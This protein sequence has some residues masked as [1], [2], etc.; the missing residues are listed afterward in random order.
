MKR[1]RIPVAWGLDLAKCELLKLYLADQ[2]F[3]EEFSRLRQKHVAVLSYILTA[4]FG[5]ESNSMPTFDDLD[6]KLIEVLQEDGP[7]TLGWWRLI[8]KIHELERVTVDNDFEENLLSHFQLDTVE[9]LTELIRDLRSLADQFGFDYPWAVPRLLTVAIIDSGIDKNPSDRTSL[10]EK[11][12]ANIAELVY[13]RVAKSLPWQPLQITIPAAFFFMFSESEILS[14][15]RGL[16]KRYKSELAKY[17]ISFDTLDELPKHIRWLFA[18][19]RHRL[20]PKKISASECAEYKPTN[21]TH[22]Q[23]EIRKWDK[24]LRS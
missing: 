4:Q 8:D 17:R 11:D 7:N 19:K 18:R 5:S 22:I 21:Y 23:A 13:D 6:V 10:T 15:V 1:T 16:L 2:K 20:S 12:H 24:W 3:S 14:L 9:G